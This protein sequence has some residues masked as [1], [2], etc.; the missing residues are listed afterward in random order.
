MTNI[1]NKKRAAKIRRKLKKVNSERL[2]LTVFRSSKNIS[3]QIIDDK[4]GKT[5]V[6]ASSIK[7]KKT[8]KK[9]ADFSI[10][11]AETL[12]KK[13][14]ENKITKVYFDRGSYKYH[15]RIKIFA[16][17]LRKGGLVF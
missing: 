1:I 17:T 11:V 10:Q 8:N 3:A 7:D 6:S 12:A 13:A 4:N 15:G 16:D 14:L 2:R 5:I 9:K